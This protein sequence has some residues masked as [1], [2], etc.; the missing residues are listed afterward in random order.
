[1]MGKAGESGTGESGTVTWGKRDS[2]LFSQ[3]DVWKSRTVTYW[4]KRDSHLGKAGQ[5]PIFTGAML[6]AS[7][8]R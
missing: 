6:V 1:M 2:H 7:V 3:G 8:N 5:S 4:E